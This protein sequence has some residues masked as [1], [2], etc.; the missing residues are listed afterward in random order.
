[1]P[2][3]YIKINEDN[4]FINHP[5]YDSNVKQLYP[6]HDF[7]SGPPTGWVEF[8]RVEPPKIN[9]YQKFDETKGG[10]IALAFSHNGLEYKFENG[11]YRDVWHV[12]EMTDSEKLKL[13]NS[14]KSAWAENG[15]ASWVFNEGTCSFVPPTAYPSEGSYVWDEE[16]LSWVEF[17]GS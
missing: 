8:I 17:T 13:Q 9:I 6:D 16:T 5:H 14:V 2:N 4:S 11:K 12:L 1:M 7:T 15:H 10:D 3:Y